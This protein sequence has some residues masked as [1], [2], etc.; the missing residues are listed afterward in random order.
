MHYRRLCWPSLVLLLASSAVATENWPQFRGPGARGVSDDS[1]LPDRWSATENVA[2][3]TEIPGRGWSSPIVWGQR[4][5]LTTAIDTAN[6]TEP[7]KKGLYFGG[8]RAKPPES[9]HQWKVLCLDLASGKV[10]WEALAHEGL[11]ASPTHIKNSYASETPVTDGERVYAAFG[12]VGVYCFDL[13]GK[14]LWSHKLEP[15]RTLAGWGPAASPALDGERLYVVNDNEEQSYLACLSAENGKEL[16]RVER[17][18]KSN[19]AT[20]LV[21]RNELR[22]EIVAPGR[23][24]VR[25][26]DRDGK[27]LWELGGM[28]KIVIATPY[29]EH[30][31]LYVTSGYVLDTNRPVFAIRPG[32]SGDISLA[33][34]ATSNDYVA[35]SSPQAAPY[36]PSTLVYGEQLYSLL[37]QGYLASYDARSGKEIYRKQRLPFGRA[38]TA[39]P[40]AYGGTVFCLNEDGETFVIAAGSEFKILHTNRLAED[41]MGMATPALAG[42]RLLIRTSARLYCIRSAASPPPAAGTP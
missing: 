5:F 37:D 9:L 29:A 31:L 39:S 20:P 35:W 1:R 3:K 36:N 6:K 25:S 8:E 26:Y 13:A 40:W 24:K 22:T 34:E 27:L 21:W 42:D 14:L 4:V 38:F 15:R 12:N 19:W 16:W 7:A 11:P 41:D 2:W 32:A 17:D 23:G 33:D 28:S 30:G 10:Q 18:E